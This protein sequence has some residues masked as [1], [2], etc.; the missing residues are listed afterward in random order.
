[1]LFLFGFPK[2]LFASRDNGQSQES[3]HEQSGEFDEPKTGPVV[4]LDYVDDNSKTP[5][6]KFMYFVPLVSPV[7]VVRKISTENS[8]VS[9]FTSYVRKGDDDSFYVKCGF[10]M[11]GSGFYRNF[12]E[13][14]SV[15]TRGLKDF[16]L[17]GK[18][19]L[20]NVLEFINF[21]GEGKGYI[22]V[23][24]FIENGEAMANKVDVHFDAGDRS[25]V[26]AGLYSVK[27]EDGEYYYRNHYNEIVARI[28][29]LSF[30]RP[31]PGEKPKM[32]IKLSSVRN[33][34]EKEGFWQSMKAAIANL[35]IDPLTISEKGNNAMLDFG[36][37]LYNK[38]PRFIFPYA[39]NIK[40]TVRVG[41]N[42]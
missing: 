6:E 7:T 26:T 20:K 31:K 12:F 10:E 9:R 22:E 38:E 42:K 19:P 24:G 40:D 35:F 34:D 28:N 13:P 4:E 5:V 36:E 3:L 2:S 21:E 37:V 25:P 29:V 11:L 17:K 41:E 14:N 39:D 33:R 30:S 1:M 23:W 18:K 8:L 32:A 27:P 16:E 15:I